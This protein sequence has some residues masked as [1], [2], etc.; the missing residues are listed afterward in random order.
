M[1][2]KK[3]SKMTLKRN[4]WQSFFEEMNREHFGW[5]TSVSFSKNIGNS[6]PSSETPSLAKLVFLHRGEKSLIEL[7]VGDN[8]ENHRRYTIFEPQKIELDKIGRE[9]SIFITGADA[10]RVLIT[11]IQPEKHFT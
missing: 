2:Y 10:A 5:K 6:L 4:C 8:P 7:V 11:L 1:H 9:V 3:M